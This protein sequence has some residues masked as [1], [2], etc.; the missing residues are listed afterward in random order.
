[1][2]DGETRAHILVLDD[3]PLIRQMVSDFLGDYDYR[4]TAVATGVEMSEVLRLERV[5]LLV[6]DLRLPGDDGMQIARRLRAE[7][8]L[9]II[10]VTGRHEEADRVMALELGADD[11]VTKPFSPRE[12]L[13][14]VRALLRRTQAHDV[15]LAPSTT[16]VRIFR[17]AGWQ[18]TVALRRMTSPHG[19]QIPLSNA[20]FNLLVAF[21]G[22]PNRILSRS[23]LL[24]LSRLHDD[25]VYDRS[26]DVQVARLRRKFDL[27]DAAPTMIRTE[28]GVGYVFNA[29]VEVIR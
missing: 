4:V 14:R 18:L 1:M 15:P 10:V 22:A 21:L 5:D 29:T 11:Y 17:F 3:D 12:L 13:A 9:A 7:S 8:D 20:E 2:P 23:E 27:Q 28:R 6:L 26:I 24:T 16:G 19:E 25:E